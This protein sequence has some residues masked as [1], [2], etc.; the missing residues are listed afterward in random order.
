MNYIDSLISNCEI[1]R[2]TIPISE[3]E[4]QDLE[5]L[6][7]IGK[8]I[9]IVEEIKG[10]VKKTFTDFSKFKESEK[11]IVKGR[12]CPKLN[13]P[14]KIMY[15]GS[16][17]TNIRKRIEQHKGLGYPGTYALHLGHW[18]KG[19]YKI[20]IKEYKASLS[21]EVLQIIEDSLSYDLSPAFGKKGGNN[22]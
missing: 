4:L 3:F 9:Y 13:K 2:K 20:T 19:S 18:F 15:V 8:A 17:V 1:A 11:K 22:K 12:K 7:G 21:K 14:S 16:S 5:V 6:D 10:D